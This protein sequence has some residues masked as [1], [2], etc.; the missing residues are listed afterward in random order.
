MKRLLL[1]IF[2][3]L[4]VA[5]ALLTPAFAQSKGKVYYLVPTLLDEF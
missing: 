3:V 1:S 5:M 4:A 2:G